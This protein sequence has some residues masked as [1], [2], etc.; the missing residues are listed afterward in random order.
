MLIT[1][2]ELL[3]ASGVVVFIVVEVVFI[4]MEVVFIVMDRDMDGTRMGLL[5]C[6]PIDFLDIHKSH[7]ARLSSLWCVK[8]K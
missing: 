2:L 8:R 6:V 4:V 7:S 5:A 3:A 1:G